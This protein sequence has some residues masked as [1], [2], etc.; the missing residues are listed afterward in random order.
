VWLRD[1]FWLAV[2]AWAVLT[3][4]LY[5][6]FGLAILGVTRSGCAAGDSLPSSE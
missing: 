2:I 6:F 5:S 4:V 3:S 1:Y